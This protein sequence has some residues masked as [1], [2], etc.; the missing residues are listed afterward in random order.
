[1]NFFKFPIL[2]FRKKKNSNHFLSVN[3]THEVDDWVIPRSQGWQTLAKDLLSRWA[4][5]PI[6]Q[7]P[8]HRKK[9]ERTLF[10]IFAVRFQDSGK[11][12]CFRE[13]GRIFLIDFTISH[14][15]VVSKRKLS[16]YEN[17]LISLYSTDSKISFHNHIFIHL[18]PH[19]W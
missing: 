9:D 17:N 2:S 15:S 13:K 19:A 12:R 3:N 5:G 18:C 14:P 8:K 6:N 16:K 11:N 4:D 10:K 1:M 7:S